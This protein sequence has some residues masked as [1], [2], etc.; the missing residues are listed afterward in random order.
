MPSLRL[1]RAFWQ[2]RRVFVTGH[3]GFMGGWLCLSLT[4]LGAQV[5]GYALQPPTR[6]SLFDCVGL[7]DRMCSMIAD[8]RDL[9]RLTAA[10]KDFAPE[11]VMHLAAQPLVGQA[12]VAPVETFATNV[13]GTVNM[14]QA[15]RQCPGVIAAIVVTT[16]KVYENREWAWG[17]RETD[18]LGGHEAYSGSKACAELAVAAYRRAYFEGKRRIGV[19][20]VRAG[21]IIG[22]G[23]WAANRLV[24]DAIR[25]F[26]ARRPLAI[27]NPASVR[28][29]QHVIDPVRGYLALAERLAVSPDE[30]TGAWNFGPAEADSWP[31]GQVADE[32]AKL[33]GED[34]RWIKPA[35][36]ANGAADL[37]REA[38]QLVLSSAK[39]QAVLGWTPVWRIQRALA[40][41]V[42]WYKAQLAGRDMHAFTL[43]QIAVAEGAN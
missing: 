18:T 12:H 43:S 6:P 24:P 23:D 30:W 25:A 3:T 14:M 27:R 11:I 13:M 9:E 1:D 4:R 34:A 2:G 17:Y 36:P 10:I 33:W 8:V 37:A 16:D 15:I 29:W 32:I 28:P 26:G 31:V 35:A 42:D 7:G 20:T 39:A 40:A 41:T 5:A 21:N 22:G 38:R 19:A